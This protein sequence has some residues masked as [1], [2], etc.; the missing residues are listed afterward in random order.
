MA[1]S[2]NTPKEN[3]GDSIDYAHL[4]EK[5]EVPTHRRKPNRA[6]LLKYAWQIT[7][8]EGFYVEEN[9]DLGVNLKS[10][11]IHPST[12][13]DM[14]NEIL[15]TYFA[16]EEYNK[17]EG[18]D[19]IIVRLVRS[20]WQRVAGYPTYFLTLEASDGCLYEAKVFQSMRDKFELLLFRPAKYNPGAESRSSSDEFPPNFYLV[21]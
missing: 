2:T 20:N 13:G 12:E 6:N 8:S 9:L 16:V 21:W 4:F 1:D 17:K 3:D 11:R 10:G 18:K 14:D 19:L 7:E 15:A 5:R